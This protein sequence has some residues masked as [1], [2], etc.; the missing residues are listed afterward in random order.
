M[1]ARAAKLL[2]RD[3][4]MPQGSGFPRYKEYPSILNPEFHE[5]YIQFLDT[6]YAKELFHTTRDLDVGRLYV[7][8]GFIS[9]TMNYTSKLF[10]KP[11]NL[12]KNSSY[13]LLEKLKQDRPRQVA[14]LKHYGIE[15]EFMVAQTR[16]SL[17]PKTYDR[18]VSVM[19]DF[20][21][22]VDYV[23]TL[24][25][26][27]RIDRDET[28]KK[29]KSLPNSLIPAL[30]RLK[31]Y[32]FK[33]DVPQELLPKRN[34]NIDRFPLL[35]DVLRKPTRLFAEVDEG[36][37]A[38]LTGK[39]SFVVRFELDVLKDGALFLGKQQPSI[40]DKVAKSAAALF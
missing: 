8:F 17:V 14:K 21:A 9:Y 10:R 29:I 5:L 28:D 34:F 13:F 30:Y 4:G 26:K 11:Y 16:V 3:M 12:N 22:H 33:R 24:K 40:L 38:H 31:G 2:L 25:H 15:R 18:D 6:Q 32:M 35:E 20:N 23:F 7:V 1:S 19:T 27:R 36:V 37:Y 39:G